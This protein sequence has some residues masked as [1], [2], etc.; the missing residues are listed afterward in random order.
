MTTTEHLLPAHDTI[1]RIGTVPNWTE[2]LLFVMYDSGA[3]LA[4]WA[5]W[6]RVPARPDLWEAVLALYLPG[7]ELLLHRSFGAGPDSSAA[8]SGPLSF[9]CVEPLR[10]WSVRLDGM[11]RRASTA[12]VTAAPLADGPWQPVRFEAD[13]EGLAPA[14][15]ARGLGEQEWADGHLEQPGRI[16]GS[17]ELDGR[18]VTFAT[19]GFRDHSYGPRDY[20]K[21]LGDVWV[22]GVFPSGRTLLAIVVWT[23][24]T[25]VPPYVVGFVDDENGRQQVTDLHAPR[26]AGVDGAPTEFT[27]ELVTAAGTA[28]I[29]V[30]MKHRTNYTL[31]NPVGMTLGTRTG[32]DD[33]IAVEGPA[34]LRWDGEET[35]GW[36][37]RFW[38]RNELTG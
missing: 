3:G 20:A 16:T 8:S 27:A 15:S 7:G 18:R 11:M 2:N 13:F 21:I 36:I 23:R 24:G 26:L 29:E 38:R 10:R 5:H 9:R 14:W 34:R 30:A 35:D 31:D 6:S 33:L 32:A 25:E 37:E 28:R 17:A 19:A 12:E 22:S 4:G 1:Q